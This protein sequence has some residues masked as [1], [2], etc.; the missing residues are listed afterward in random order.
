MISD[1]AGLKL[2]RKNFNYISI[3]NDDKPRYKHL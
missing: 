2:N 3:T 1:S